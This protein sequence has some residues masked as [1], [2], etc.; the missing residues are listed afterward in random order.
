M[1]NKTLA[2]DKGSGPIRHDDSCGLC[3]CARPTIRSELPEACFD[4]HGN[5][6]RALSSLSSFPAHAEDLSKVCGGVRGA[7]CSTTTRNHPTR[8]IR[9]E[10]F[11]RSCQVPKV[12][13][14]IVPPEHLHTCC[15]TQ[16]QQQA[17][18]KANPP[19]SLLLAKPKLG[20]TKLCV[21]WAW[22]QCTTILGLWTRE[23][24]WRQCIA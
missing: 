21:R 24:C 3:N 20:T 15:A 18:A 16:R 6:V 13:G 14:H 17:L 11:L 1:L 19:G 12:K 8:A 9:K 4:R 22:E 10:K 2:I 23:D 7:Q 5:G